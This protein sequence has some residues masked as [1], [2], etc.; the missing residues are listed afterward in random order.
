MD[1]I[2][3]N[4]M[5]HGGGASHISDLSPQSEI[6]GSSI[7]NTRV[8]YDDTELLYLISYT[9]FFV[10]ELHLLHYALI[11]YFNLSTGKRLRVICNGTLATVHAN[12][13]SLNLIIHGMAEYHT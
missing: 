12:P 3:L 8:F 2:P 10:V 4:L 7:E 13:D 11:K 6:W 9:S 5:I 1:P